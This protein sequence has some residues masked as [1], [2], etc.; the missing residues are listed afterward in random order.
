MLKEVLRF[1]DKNSPVILTTLGVVGVV[2]TTLTAVKATPKAYLV[3]EKAKKEM[4]NLEDWSKEKRKEMKS[5][6]P[7]DKRAIQMV[8]DVGT[9]YI[10]T[11][12]IGGT[13][14]LCI[15]SANRIAS[16]RT[17]ALASLY[18]MAEKSLDRYKI[19]A[20]ELIG[21]K[22]MQKVKDAVELEKVEGIPV[23]T[24]PQAIYATGR[25]NS[26]CCETLTGRYFRS[27][28]EQIRKT[29]NDI[30]FELL[31]SMYVSLNDLYS[32]LGL[33]RT[34]FGDEVGWTANELIEPMF[35]C[36]MSETGEPCLVVSFNVNPK[37]EF[38]E[39]F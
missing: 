15:I 28:I 14:I 5:L 36:K 29:V 19:K 12:I 9:L 27:D 2:T 23:P 31:N 17:V 8:R 37:Y 24:E 1:L 10:P 18:S 21:E 6:S 32:E 4:D 38:K 3:V 16:K 35:T 11:F 22:K 30:N 7:K 26:L 25:G 20:D 34:D 33:P 39:F 13:T